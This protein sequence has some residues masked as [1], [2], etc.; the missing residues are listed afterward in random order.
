MK[1]QTS[2]FLLIA[3][4]FFSQNSESMC[5]FKCTA[6]LGAMVGGLTEAKYN[7]NSVMYKKSLDLFKQC[8]SQCT[9]NSVK[10]FKGAFVQNATDYSVCHVLRWREYC[11]I[12]SL[13]M[14]GERCIGE[15][16][17]DCALAT[18]Q[19]IHKLEEIARSEKTEPESLV[20]ISGVRDFIN[21]K[22]DVIEEKLAEES[23]RHVVTDQNDPQHRYAH[24]IGGIKNTLQIIT[25]P[26]FISAAIQAI[27]PK[28][29]ATLKNDPKALEIRNLRLEL[30][31]GILKILIQQGKIPHA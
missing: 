8:W 31:Y 7:Q 2:I 18:K 22:F 10:N 11:E 12:K 15:S 19:L 4:S 9:P 26:S 28:G 23:A 13:L 21:R 16:S 29:T 24:A 27:N 30:Y 20:R 6:K 3:A 1:K 25:L 14:M 17:L 5:R